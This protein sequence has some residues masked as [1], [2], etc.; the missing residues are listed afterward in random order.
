MLRSFHYNSGDLLSEIQCSALQLQQA[1]DATWGNHPPG[2]QMTLIG[3]RLF[4]VATHRE[5][6]ALTTTLIDHAAYLLT[7]DDARREFADGAVLVQDHVIEW[8]GPSAQLDAKRRAAVDRVVDARHKLVM[9]GMVNTHHHFFQTLTRVI[10]AAQ[11][12]ILFDWLKTLYPIWVNLTPPDVTIST[13]LALMELLL[14][15]CTTSSDHHYLWPNGTRLDDQF[16]AAATIGVRFHGARGSMSL[17]ESQGGL[18][19]DAATEDE[20]FILRDSRRVVET[21][22]DPEP[23]ALRRVA[24]AP[25]SPFSVTQALMAESA[26]LARSFKQGV[27]L[28]TH[29]AETQDEEAFCIAQFGLRPTAYMEKLGWLGDDVWHAHCVH[30]N[31]SE[32]AQF[33]ATL[34]GVAHCPTSNMRLA[35]GIAPIRTML[36]AGVSVGLGVDGSASN[37][38]S[39]LLAEARQA[40][41]LQRVLG[42]PAAMTARQALELATRGGA[43]VLGRD[44]IGVLAPGMAADI[45]GFD[46]D[47]PTFAGGAV[48]DPVAALVFCQPQQVDFALVHGRLLVE[49]GAPVGHDLGRLVEEHNRAAR[50]LV[51]RAGLA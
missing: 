44:D 38:G 1:R 37:D 27:R 39:H 43:Q 16:E 50:A 41:L 19:P 49:A 35:S 24:L 5:G 10:P 12:A 45:I 6:I 30:M 14:S 15:G 29:L 36:Q 34:T 46:L 20:D 13:Q 28:H 4:V 18:P 40:M 3:S 9:P 23:Y 21:Y 22:H 8:V 25:C 17:G 32:I 47:V 51:Q 31:A 11:N 26:E 48:H 33:A 7:M 42:N 2:S